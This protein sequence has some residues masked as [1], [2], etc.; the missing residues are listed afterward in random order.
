MIA[1]DIITLLESFSPSVGDIA[2]LFTG[3]S[4]MS[5][6]MLNVIMQ[7][8]DG[9]L[10]EKIATWSQTFTNKLNDLGPDAFN[11]DFITKSLQSADSDDFFEVM[12]ATKYI[13]PTINSQDLDAASNAITTAIKA[14]NWQ[15]AIQVGL[16]LA[17]FLPLVGL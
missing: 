10:L 15:Q 16:S 7:A 3:F 5:P 2:S 17:Q 14:E 1:S 11:V 12:K 4:K 13:G 6:N 8:M 9:N